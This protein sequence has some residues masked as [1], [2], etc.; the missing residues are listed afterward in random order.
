VSVAMDRVRLF[1]ELTK[2]RALVM[3]VFTTAISYLIAVTDAP[4]AWV[5]FH[6]IVGVTLSAGGSLALNQHMEAD[7][8]A[9]M[10]RTRSRPIPSGRLPRGAAFVFGMITMLGGFGY[11]YVLVNPACCWATVACGVSYNY[12]YTPMKLRTSFSSF[13]GAIPGGMLPVMGWAAAQ[14]KIEIG[15]WVLFVILFFW[16]IPHALIISIRH[17]TDYEGVGMKQLPIVMTGEASQRQMLFNTLALIPVTVLPYL[18]NLTELVY[19]VVALLLGLFLLVQVI[20]YMTKATESRAR[21][22]FISLSAYLPLL[23]LVMYLDKPA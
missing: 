22:L 11:L 14:G 18:L 23:L 21:R 20:A 7:L 17:K 4:D 12:L 3:I 16:Q 19:P 1:V 13:V 15:A 2:P 9:R 6:T 10:A 8:D 5:L